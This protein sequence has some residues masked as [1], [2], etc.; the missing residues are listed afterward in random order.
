MGT[1][2]SKK[3]EQALD[4]KPQMLFRKLIFYSIICIETDPMIN[5]LEKQVKLLESRYKIS[6]HG[7]ELCSA[8]ANWSDNDFSKLPKNSQYELKV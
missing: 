3:D 2:C 7:F 4:P 6:K 5:Q 1:A 8:I